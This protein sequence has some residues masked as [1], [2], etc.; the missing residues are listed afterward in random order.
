MNQNQIQR[1]RL[2]SALTT[3]FLA[4]PQIAKAIQPGSPFGVPLDCDPLPRETAAFI[5]TVCEK[6][7]GVLVRGTEPGTAIIVFKDAILKMQKG[8]KTTVVKSVP[9]IPGDGSAQISVEEAVRL[10]SSAKP[11]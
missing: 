5:E 8:G 4:I 1:S 3:I 6:G 11:N 2:G 10:T 9:G 7:S